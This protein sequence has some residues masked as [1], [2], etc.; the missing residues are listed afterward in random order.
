[1]TVGQ[2]FNLPTRTQFAS[3]L[4]RGGVVFANDAIMMDN[5]KG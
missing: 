1:M 3:R 5:M 4:S 2:V